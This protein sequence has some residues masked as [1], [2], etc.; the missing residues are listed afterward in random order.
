MSTLEKLRVYKQV[1]LK[2]RS[3]L[4]SGR[5]DVVSPTS[6][7]KKFFDS[8]DDG[9]N[10]RVPPCYSVENGIDT[11][12]SD[13]DRSRKARSDSKNG[14]VSPRRHRCPFVEEAEGWRV[15]YCEYRCQVC[16]CVCVCVCSVSIHSCLHLL[17]AQTAR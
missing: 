12:E 2:I 9:V 11:E 8:S 13:L 15:E 10:R 14:G 17:F 5:E 3:T 16:V 4:V 6:I 7:T 1:C